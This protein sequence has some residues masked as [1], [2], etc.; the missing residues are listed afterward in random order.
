MANCLVGEDMK[1][2][3]TKAQEIKQTEEYIAFL[4]K[5]LDSKNYKANVS[6]EEY[7]KEKAKLDK[8]KFRLKIMKTA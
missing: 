3:L 1:K 8:A 4:R 5:R 6:A 7:E 2:K